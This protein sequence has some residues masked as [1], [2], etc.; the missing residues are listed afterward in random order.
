[1]LAKLGRKVKCP[2]HE[3]EKC[4]QPFEKLQVCYTT[5]QDPEDSKIHW[6]FCPWFPE[7]LITDL[8]NQMEK[9]GYTAKRVEDI[10]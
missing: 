2:H 8:T 4:I 10:E 1:V 3:N 9:D 5:E 6:Y 7:A